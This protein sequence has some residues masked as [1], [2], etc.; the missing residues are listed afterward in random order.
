MYSTFYFWGL[1]LSFTDKEYI[2]TYHS[3]CIAKGCICIYYSYFTAKWYICTYYSYFTSTWYICTFSSYFTRKGTFV[4]T[5]RILLRKGSFVLTTR[6]LKSII[7]IN[8]PVSHF[9]YHRQ[10][11]NEMIL[12]KRQKKKVLS[13]SQQHKIY[14]LE[15]KLIFFIE[16]YSWNVLL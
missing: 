5:I 4:L 12:L 14:A 8:I 10:I 1:P 9:P 16:W 11:T 7:T 15:I 6:I 13:Y 2:C 3:Y